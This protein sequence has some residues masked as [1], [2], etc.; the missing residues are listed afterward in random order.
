LLEHP[1]NELNPS[2][3]LSVSRQLTFELGEIHESM[4]DAKIELG[5]QTEAKKVGCSYHNN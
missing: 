3:Y 2:I 1:L 4:M 5:R